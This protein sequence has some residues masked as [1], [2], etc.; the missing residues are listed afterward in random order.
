M[1]TQNECYTYFNIVGK[2]DPDDVTQLLGI[3]PFKSW[4][5]GDLRANGSQF[6]F[7]SW[8]TGL[9]QEYDVYVEN[10]MRKTLEGLWEKIDL[11]NRIR[12]ENEVAFYLEVVPTVY[13][14]ESTPCLA[15][16][17]D[18]IDFCHATRT[19]IDIDLYVKD[20]PMLSKIFRRKDRIESIK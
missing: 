15:P 12:E 4:K 16:T 19:Q 5:I 14:V 3:Q 6:D 13:P 17:L 18:I 7:A 9:C 11:L 10:Q 1:K 20:T 2:F 8:K